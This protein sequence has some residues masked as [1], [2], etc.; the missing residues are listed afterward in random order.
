MQICDSYVCSCIDQENERGSKR[1]LRVENRFS[2]MQRRS[3]LSGASGSR[4]LPRRVVHFMCLTEQTILIFMI[5]SNRPFNT[6][7]RSTSSLQILHKTKHETFSRRRYASLPFTEPYETRNWNTSASRAYDA[8]C[9][10]T[11]SSNCCMVISVQSQMKTDHYTSR[12]RSVLT[13]VRRVDQLSLVRTLPILRIHCVFPVFGRFRRL[14]RDGKQ[15]IV[16]FESPDDHR[17]EL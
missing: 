4:F 9:G 12:F 14:I 6:L 1:V 17:F 10:N 13:V 15:I 3:A 11:P 7:K 2:D 8:R 5:T 16:H